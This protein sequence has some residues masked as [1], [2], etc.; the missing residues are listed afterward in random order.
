MKNQRIVRYRTFQLSVGRPVQRGAAVVG[1]GA[2]L[3][4]AGQE[5]LAELRVPGAGREVQRRVAEVVLRADRDAAGQEDL[6]CK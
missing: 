4:A 1:F 5:D 2:G 3:R 6:G